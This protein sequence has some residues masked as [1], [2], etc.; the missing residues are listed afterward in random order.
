M[1]TTFCTNHIRQMGSHLT[2]ALFFKNEE[3]ARLAKRHGL[4]ILA[5]ASGVLAAVLLSKVFGLYCI[6]GMTILHLFLWGKLHFDNK[7]YE[8]RAKKLKEEQGR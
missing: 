4:M 5:F 8:E 1:A 6:F 2:Q 7:S 3:S